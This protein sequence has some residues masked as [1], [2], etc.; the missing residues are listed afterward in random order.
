MCEGLDAPDSISQL[1]I[2]YWASIGASGNNVHA[3]R[4]KK[5]GKI[6]PRGKGGIVNDFVS[7]FF[8]I[9]S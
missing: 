9:L 4:L 3:F 1:N 6:P 7:D 5:T 8:Q 2:G